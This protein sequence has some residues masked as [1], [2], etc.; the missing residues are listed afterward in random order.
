[1]IETKVIST[2]SPALHPDSVLPFSKAGENVTAAVKRAL[3]SM[4]SGLDAM[5]VAEQATRQQFGVG[6][7]A[8]GGTIKLAI[9]PDRAATL[10]ADLG[11][12]F[13]TIARGFDTSLGVVNDQIATLQGRVDKA[14]I[15]S[16]R[17]AMAS[18]EAQDMRKYLTSLPA[19]ERMN[20]L[21]S[22]VA[23]GDI[24]LC[25]A[26]LASPF[27]AGLSR[28]QAAVLRSLSAEKFCAADFEALTA[29]KAMHSHLLG[30]SAT[31][32]AAY[33]K[34]LPT[35]KETPHSAATKALKA[36]A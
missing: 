25:H 18:G 32:L 4:Y 33:K 19:N 29:S 36:E 2:V 5:Q 11:T 12:R 15:S 28:D 20:V 26:A 8:D 24:D 35:V 17:D 10:H 27:A 16:K 22:A 1:M 31:F 7:V 13:A 34:L 30:S 21:H 6:Q 14:L 23:A 9:P 3:G